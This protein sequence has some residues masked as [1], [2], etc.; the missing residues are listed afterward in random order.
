M[1]RN[2]AIA[3]LMLMP[4]PKAAFG[5]HGR[6][7]LLTQTARLGDAG[8]LFV[9]ARQDY[10]RSNS[11]GVLAF[12]PLI[13]WTAR[14]W[15]SLE[16][17]ADIEKEKGEPHEYE[18]TV[19]GARIRVDIE[20]YPVV[21]GMAVRYAIASDDESHDALKLSALGSY[22]LNGFLFGFNLNYKKPEGAGGEWGYALAAKQELRHHLSLGMEVS[23]S[24]EGD[25]SGEV[26]GGMY[27]EPVHGIQ[28]NVGVGTGFN[29]DLDVTFKTALIWWN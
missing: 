28:I 23:G 25:A 15:V 2:I 13:A 6:D 16:I 10:A 11:E 5:D 20:D 27:Y 17:N 14:D 21:L 26:V 8:S 1:K 3:M 7:F 12:E 9:I 22:H 19:P 4:L 29:S 18:A 24:F